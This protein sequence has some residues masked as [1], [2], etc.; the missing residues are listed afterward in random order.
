[1]FISKRDCRVTPECDCPFTS[2]TSDFDFGCFTPTSSYH[3]W[4]STIPLVFLSCICV[5]HSHRPH[6]PLAR[7]EM[8]SASSSDNSRAVEYNC[9]SSKKAKTFSHRPQAFNLPSLPVEDTAPQLRSADAAS[10]ALKFHNLPVIQFHADNPAH[11]EQFGKLFPLIVQERLDNVDKKS[12][13][14]CLQ[15][16]SEL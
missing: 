3:H 9:R 16:N 5:N 2:M 7:T 15:P 10:R 13:A 6:P 11:M 14:D 4:H 1:M 12:A 8:S